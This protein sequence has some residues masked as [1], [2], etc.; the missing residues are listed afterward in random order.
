MAQQVDLFY[1]KT[2]GPL[3]KGSNAPVALINPSWLIEWHAKGN[4]RIP[5]R[6]DLPEDAVYTGSTDSGNFIA[7][8]YPWL[9]VEHPDPDGHHLDRVVAYVRKYTEQ[10]YSRLFGVFWD[11]MSLHQKPRTADED[12]LF[13]KAL[14]CMEIWYG[15]KNIDALRVT[16]VPEGTVPYDQRG[17]CTFETQ[18]LALSCKG[19]IATLRHDKDKSFWCDGDDT[20]TLE[21]VKMDMLRGESPLPAPLIPAD[22]DALIRTKTFTNQSDAD[23][24]SQL[25]SNFYH[26]SMDNSKLLQFSGNVSDDNAHQMTRFLVET[27]RLKSSW[28]LINLQVQHGTV[29][30]AGMHDILTNGMNDSGLAR[31]IEQLDFQHSHIGD[32]GGLLF[33]YALGLGQPTH[34]QPFPKLYGLTLNNC[35]HIDDACVGAIA[36]CVRNLPVGGTQ[37]INRPQKKAMW[38]MPEGRVTCAGRVFESCQKADAGASYLYRN[39]V[40]F[41]NRVSPS[42]IKTFLKNVPNSC[43]CDTAHGPLTRKEVEWEAHPYMSGQSTVDCQVCGKPC[44]PKSGGKGVIYRCMHQGK[45]YSPDKKA[46]QDG[47]CETQRCEACHKECSDVRESENGRVQLW[48]VMRY[49]G[50][51]LVEEDGSVYFGHIKDGKPHGWGKNGGE[52]GVWNEGVLVNTPAEHAAFCESLLAEIKREKEEKERAET[53]ERERKARE[54]REEREREERERQE[55]IARE[56]ERERMEREE[57][58]EREDKE[59]LEQELEAKHQQLSDKQVVS[60]Y[61]SE[62]TDTHVMVV[63]GEGKSVE[64]CCASGKEGCVVM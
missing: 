10:P 49:R 15:H 24:V 2:T 5:R 42:E 27:K 9:S 11:Y 57:R 33:A 20:H 56:N 59:R 4:R 43:P 60:V 40:Q 7:V 35:P 51:L 17:W 31:L 34:T 3:T 13:K 22:F 6:Q 45:V 61:D 18:V 64:G 14:G 50:G 12:V 26:V 29:G 38:F 62:H 8:S 46:L 48:G 36:A 1:D 37:T 25:Y 23:T 47:K 39:G 21:D 16:E 54:E 28:S 19:R 53:E 52:E 55:Q 32:R 30:D 63:E 41:A 44:A 58:E